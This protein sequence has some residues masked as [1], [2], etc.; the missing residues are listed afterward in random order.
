MVRSLLDSTKAF[1]GASPTDICKPTKDTLFPVVDPTFAKIGI[2]TSDE[3]WGKA[4]EYAVHAIVATGKTDWVRDVEDEK[5]SVMEALAKSR[6][7]SWMTGSKRVMISA[8]NMPPP[9]EYYAAEEQKK[10]MP[11]TV[12]LLPSFTIVEHVTPQDTPELIRRFIHPGPTTRTLLG[13]NEVG[14]KQ[15]DAGVNG[16]SKEVQVEKE[17]GEETVKEEKSGTPSSSE[18]SPQNGQTSSPS[19]LSELPTAAIATLSLS[20]SPGDKLLSHPCS[21]DYIILLCSHRRRDA[22]CG[23]SAPILLREFE[24]H[25]RPL[26]LYRDHSDNRPGGVGIY[27]INHIGGHKYAGN[28]L[29]YRKVDGMGV[30]LGRVAPKHV[31]GIVKYTIL[32]GKIVHPEQIRGGFYRKT[33]MVSW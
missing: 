4:N 7:G 24:R 26:G 14:P 11:T 21:H 32:Q 8:S 27:F 28:V 10:P 1:L 19:N 13:A 18:K 6:T 30:W 16:E 33:G 2:N 15:S 29:L 9:P 23:I 5:G 12:L 3:L 31:E 20:S 17:G 25:L 22:R